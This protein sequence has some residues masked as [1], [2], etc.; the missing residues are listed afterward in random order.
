MPTIKAA[1]ENAVGPARQRELVVWQ[2]MHDTYMSQ[3][4]ELVPGAQEVRRMREEL[5]DLLREIGFE[6]TP[7]DSPG[8]QLRSTQ[9]LIPSVQPG[10]PQ[11]ITETQARSPA[12]S[13][14]SPPSAEAGTDKASL[15]LPNAHH[16]LLRALPGQCQTMR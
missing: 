6:D 3:R 16:C 11:A 4:L 10:R 2:A 1:F 15:E 13:R 5:D 7:P 14:G 12:I 9:G 8:S